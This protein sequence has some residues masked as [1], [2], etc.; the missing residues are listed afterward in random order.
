MYKMDMVTQGQILNEAV[1]SL[2]YAIIT[3]GKSMHQTAM[4]K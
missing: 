2:H 4:S 1:C 3:L